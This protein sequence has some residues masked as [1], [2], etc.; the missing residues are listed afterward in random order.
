[1]L[2]AQVLLFGWGAAAEEVLKELSSVGTEQVGGSLPSSA[3]LCISQTSQAKDCDLRDVC[4]A[5][6][7]ECVLCDSEAEILEKARGFRPDLIV[8]ASYRKKL[9]SSVL[10][11]CPDCINFHPSLLPK[12]RGCWSGFWCIFEGDSETGVTCH[13]MVEAFDAG[14]VLHREHIAVEAVDTAFTVYRK[15][16][17][18]TARCARQVF[19]WYFSSEG[20]PAG[21]EQKGESS[22]HYRKLPFDGLIQQEWSDQQVERFIRAMNFPPFDGAAILVDDKRVL[23]DSL[24]VQSILGHA[25]PRLPCLAHPVASGP[26]KHRE[27][28]LKYRPTH[29][30]WRLARHGQASQTKA[31]SIPSRS[32]LNIAHVLRRGCTAKT[33][34]VAALS[35]GIVTSCAFSVSLH[36]VRSD[37]WA[38]P[39]TRPLPLSL[40]YQDVN[41]GAVAKEV[42]PR[43]FTLSSGHE[44]YPTVG[45]AGRNIERPSIARSAARSASPVAAYSLPAQVA[46][47]VSPMGPASASSLATRP[48]VY[49]GSAEAVASTAPYAP[50]LPPTSGAYMAPRPSMRC[51]A[52]SRGPVTWTTSQL[53][54]DAGAG[55]QRARSESPLSPARV[56][57]EEASA[58]K[59]QEGD[60]G[61]PLNKNNGPPSESLGASPAPPPLPL[62]LGYKDVGPHVGLG[63]ENQVY[64]MRYVASYTDSQQ[65]P[66]VAALGNTHT[67][68]SLSS[69]AASTSP[70]TAQRLTAQAVKRQEGDEGA[71][72]N[73]NNGPP[74]E[75]LGASPAPPPLPLSLGYKDVGPHVSLGTEN[76]VY[77]MRYVASYTDSQ[78]MPT[79]AALGN[80]HTVAS[81]SSAA[82]STSPWTA[83]RLTAQAARG[84]PM[85]Q[86]ISNGFFVARPFETACSGQVEVSQ[87]FS[88]G[89]HLRCVSWSPGATAAQVPMGSQETWFRQG[90]QGSS[91]PLSGS[92]GQ[93]VS[94]FKCLPAGCARHEWHPEAQ[95]PAVGPAPVLK[96]TS[97]QQPLAETASRL[98]QKASQPPSQGSHLRC[99]SWSPGATAAQVPMVSQ[100]LPYS[101]EPSDSW[102]V[103]GIQTSSSPPL[104]GS[105]GQRVSPFKCLPA[106]CTRHEWDPEA[107]RP[108]AEPAPVTQASD[109]EQLLAEAKSRLQQKVNAAVTRYMEAP[110]PAEPAKPAEP[111]APG[112]LPERAS[113][114][115][116]KLG[117]CEKKSG[118]LGV[119]DQDMPK[120][121][122]VKPESDQEQE[123]QQW[124]GQA[125]GTVPQL[126]ATL[127]GLRAHKFVKW[128]QYSEEQIQKETDA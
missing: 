4:A 35:Y 2:H 64:P 21:E 77:P 18:V 45:C 46:R 69:A 25:L 120:F 71:P 61:A 5:L 17:P 13:R 31:Y 19:R 94:P 38:F 101:R 52:W 10:S 62:S 32:C 72:L 115:L 102:F 119:Q 81:L 108:P 96:A 99:V 112:E 66:T 100:V 51:I 39:I 12:H 123:G 44:V 75:S 49:S 30:I 16:L 107:P 59:R 95:R 3:I 43:S 98:Q 11:L 23:V 47:S 6:G 78:Q 122:E 9:P 60:E 29:W 74:S 41:L 15:L 97:F 14:L 91:P 111:I 48:L 93:Y 125:Q 88:Q 80:T 103:P 40:G 113:K 20:L 56:R 33:G 114:E 67:V 53:A 8:S 24:E 70:W 116:P 106:G 84:R 104:C 128:L 42:Y 27:Q 118:L 28:P 83:Q 110:E 65:M 58:V 73:K 124:P 34:M 1:M 57:A 36:V 90:I 63:T 117:P 37:D 92:V 26:V 127:T 7:C 76:Q 87:P 54:S 85:S 86:T 105:V 79:V 126:L 121:A 55:E 68:A 50:V 22:Y 89:S 82:A 109:F